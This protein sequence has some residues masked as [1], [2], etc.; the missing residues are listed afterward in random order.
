[1]LSIDPL[2]EQTT[3]TFDAA[4]PPDAD[5]R[6]RG[7]FGRAELRPQ[8]QPGE[9]G[10]SARQRHHLRL[11]RGSNREVDQIDPLGA[12]T[13][14]AYDAA[15]RV[16]SRT[17]R[18]GRS[19]EYA[20][21]AGDRL[22][23]ETWRDAG[24]LVVNTLAYTYDPNR[25]ILTA[26]DASGAYAMTYDALDR[27]TSQNGP[28]GLQLDFTYDP[29]G[30]RT[31]VADSEGGFT[32]STYNAVN[33]LTSRQ[34]AAAGSAGARPDLHGPRRAVRGGPYSDLAGTHKVGETD[35]VH[36]PAR[37]TT[38]IE[39][40]DGVGV[41]LLDLATYDL[42]GKATSETPTACRRTTPTTSPTIDRRRHAGVQL[43]PGRQ[44]DDA[45][46]RDG[47]EQPA[48]ERRHLGVRVRRR[49]QPNQEDEGRQ[50][51]TWTYGYD[52]ATR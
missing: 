33:R 34:F 13:V 12:H 31:G 43:R 9:P 41:N 45:R 39:H 49:G 6:S 5:G 3:H 15:S 1:V 52:T 20:Y 19:R 18:L 7:A 22:T 24:G 2:G 38:D 40:G 16:T 10:R 42:E 28:F 36:D 46:L 11:R 26:S 14:T 27:V 35:Y 4:Q 37:R 51:R 23:T 50:R 48:A 25:N 30:N 17:D 29:V 44:P 21:D 47:A 32:A 8:Q